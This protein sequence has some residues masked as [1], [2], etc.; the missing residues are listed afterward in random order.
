MIVAIVPAYNEERYIGKL[1]KDVKKYVDKVIVVDDGSTDKTYSVAKRHKVIVL[2]H[3]I[4]LG[5]GAAL[6]TGVKKALEYKPDYL[7]FIDADLQHDPSF[8]PKMLESIRGAD[9][10]IGCRVYS[11]E[12]PFLFRIGNMLLSSLFKLLYK[13][14]VPDTQSGYRLIRANK[15]PNWKSNDYFVEFEMLAKAAA[16]GLKVKLVSIPTIYNDATKGTNLFTGMVIG[17][18]LILYRIVNF[19]KRQTD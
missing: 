17:F 16:S 18:K 2:R 1:I 12:M 9:M 4:N 19:I 13:I 11:G 8:I 5:K 6:R 7:V 10:V 15:V 14:D 3:V